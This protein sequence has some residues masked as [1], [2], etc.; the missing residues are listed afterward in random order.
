MSLI[1]TLLMKPEVWS[2]MSLFGQGSLIFVSWLQL[3]LS[4]LE[5]AIQSKTSTSA[6]DSPPPPKKNDLYKLYTWAWDMVTWCW[7]GD[8]FWQLSINHN[9][10]VQ[11]QRHHVVPASLATIH[12]D[13]VREWQWILFLCM[14]MVL[15]IYLWCSTWEDSALK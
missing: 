15:L 9:M 3:N 6:A 10:D 2:A 5:F 8:T 4:W 13:Q 12:F 7:S 11:Y 1:S 14:Q